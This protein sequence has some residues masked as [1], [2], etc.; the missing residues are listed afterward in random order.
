MENK[1]EDIFCESDCINSEI[2][3]K[4]KSLK[5]S[6]NEETSKENSV[7]KLTLKNSFSL[8]N[9]SV[10]DSILSLTIKSVDFAAQKHANQRRKNVDQTPYINHP[11][12]EHSQLKALA[13]QALS[14][15][16]WVNRLCFFIF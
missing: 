6:Q 3:N 5:E 11:I 14:K 9:K 10:Y 15:K 12:G 2:N 13:K 7:D 8:S 1:V 4:N 16:L